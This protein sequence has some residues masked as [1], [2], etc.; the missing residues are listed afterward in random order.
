VDPEETFNYCDEH[1]YFNPDDFFCPGCEDVDRQI[2]EAI[3]RD[4]Q[5]KVDP[6]AKTQD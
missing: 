5:R 1:G 4:H 6:Y 3:E 2:D